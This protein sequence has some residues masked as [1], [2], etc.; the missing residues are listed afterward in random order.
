MQ[1]KIFQ[2]RDNIC[3]WLG[4]TPLVLAFMLIDESSTQAQ[5]VESFKKCPP[6]LFGFFLTVP[7]LVAS[8]GSC[9]TAVG[10]D[11]V[12][13][14]SLCLFCMKELHAL[15]HPLPSNIPHGD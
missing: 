6:C 1:A 14:A 5:T 10:T 8:L 2:K 3:R 13:Q 7:A 12:L 15:H 9:V 4:L 11:L